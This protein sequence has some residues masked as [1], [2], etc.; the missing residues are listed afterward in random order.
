MLAR[1][2]VLPV[3]QVSLAVSVATSEHLIKKKKVVGVDG[4]D[5]DHDL[6]GH[7]G[8]VVNVPGIS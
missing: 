3:N 4:H 1:H 8:Y 5:D 2:S 6:Y 7:A